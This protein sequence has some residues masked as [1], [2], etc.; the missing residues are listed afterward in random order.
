MFSQLLRK[1]EFTEAEQAQHEHLKG[2]FTTYDAEY[3]ARRGKC[4]TLFEEFVRKNQ[5]DLVILE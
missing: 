1:E 2:L 3:R 4:A 5:S